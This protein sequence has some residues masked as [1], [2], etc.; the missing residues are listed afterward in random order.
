MDVYCVCLFVY[1]VRIFTSSY[2]GT[3]CCVEW[4]CWDCG[5]GDGTAVR[6]TIGHARGI[7]L[8]LQKS[9]GRKPGPGGWHGGE[10][11]A[12]NFL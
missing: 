12:L 3:W 1:Y 2:L 9:T 11:E 8:S 6:G 4:G 7:G 10:S 5:N